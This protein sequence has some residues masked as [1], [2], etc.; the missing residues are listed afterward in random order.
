VHDRQKRVVTDLEF[1]SAREKAHICSCCENLFT[2]P[3]D[4]PHFCPDCGGRPVFTPGGPLP[5]PHGEAA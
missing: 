1:D 3:D 2:R 4:V 5:E